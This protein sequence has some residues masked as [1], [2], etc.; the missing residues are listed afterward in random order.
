VLLDL[1]ET[2]PGRYV[3]AASERP[4]QWDMHMS[5]RRGADRFELT[6]RI[7]VK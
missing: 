1:R 3:A 6:E 7:I 4:G 5:A 2:A